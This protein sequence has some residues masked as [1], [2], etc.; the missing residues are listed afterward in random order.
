[1]TGSPVTDLL[2]AAY[3][4][5]YP[6][7]DVHDP[8]N[9]VLVRSDIHTLL[10][11]NLLGVE[12]KTLKLHIAPSLEG[13]TYAQLAGRSLNKRLDG[14]A[15]DREVLEERWRMF[16]LAHPE[17]EQRAR[18][19]ESASYVG[20]DEDDEAKAPTS[21][22]EAADHADE[23][24]GE[25]PVIVTRPIEPAPGVSSNATAPDRSR[26]HED[27]PADVDDAETAETAHARSDVEGDAGADD[28]ERRH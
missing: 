12:P 13:T 2:E 14:S 25:S 17:L 26:D 11:L 15:I 5:P 22:H 28:E 19:D 24:E 10:D 16:R 6:T 8:S 7:G 18:R 9:A 3:L 1:V 21:A 20:S 23:A 27:D 4:V